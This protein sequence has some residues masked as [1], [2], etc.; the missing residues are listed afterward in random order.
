[1]TIR[2]IYLLLL[3]KIADPCSY[4]S[5]HHYLTNIWCLPSLK[6]TIFWELPIIAFFLHHPIL[7]LRK[8]CIS[9]KISENAF[10]L[11][12]FFTF[13]FFR[14]T[15]TEREEAGSHRLQGS[16]TVHT[17]ISV[18]TLS[19]VMRPD[20]PYSPPLLHRSATD[21]ENSSPL[22]ID[23]NPALDFLQVG[24]SREFNEMRSK[25]VQTGDLPQTAPVV[26]SSDRTETRRLNS[27]QHSK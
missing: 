16:L 21:S 19:L 27:R 24:T 15:E 5:Y 2:Y 23:L 10:L 26:N 4:V 12:L 20:N 7:I 8:S 14:E 25:R 11:Y 18:A 13:N 6:L 22:W 3:Y 1:M 9:T 17:A